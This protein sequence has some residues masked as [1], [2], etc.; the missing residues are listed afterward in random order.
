MR[1]EVEKLIKVLEKKGGGFDCLG[2]LHWNPC[3][4][5]FFN[6]IST[7]GYYP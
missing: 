3:P 2:A 5:E 4:P 7:K 1:V 6:P